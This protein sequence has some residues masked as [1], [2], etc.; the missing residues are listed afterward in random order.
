[1]GGA[2][3]RAGGSAGPS[4]GV[5]HQRIG[6][7]VTY[8]HGRVLAHPPGNFS[9]AVTGHWYAPAPGGRLRI[10]RHEGESLVTSHE[11]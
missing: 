5:I 10:G 2:S 11:P 8:Q 3:I 1:M 6:L 9:S 4:G 7:R